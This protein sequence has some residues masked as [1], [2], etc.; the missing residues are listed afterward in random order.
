M[1]KNEREVTTILGQLC[2][3]IHHLLAYARKIR[4]VNL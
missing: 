2:N 1:L 4:F 3:F